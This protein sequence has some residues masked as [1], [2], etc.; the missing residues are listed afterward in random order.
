MIHLPTLT[1]IVREHHLKCR[2]R[3][4][5]QVTIQL[6]NAKHPNHHPSYFLPRSY[7][8]LCNQTLDS[9]SNN[10]SRGTLLN[11]HFF[12]PSLAP[13]R[14]ANVSRVS[15]MA[16]FGCFGNLCRSLAS[17]PPLSITKNAHCCFK[18]STR[19]N[20][21]SS[22][23]STAILNSS[24]S[25]DGIRRLGPLG[26]FMGAVAS[27]SAVFMPLTAADEWSSV[28]WRLIGFNGIRGGSRNLPLTSGDA[29]TGLVEIL[30]FQ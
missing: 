25:S 10:Q 8:A 19:P 22:F 21:V 14:S 23:P 9:Y 2:S 29:F 17:S 5:G 7:K 6:C 4:N 11:T 28:F 3:C 13:T 16:A 27:D 24:K 26:G 12:S 15:L 30:G 20:F 1:C 18:T